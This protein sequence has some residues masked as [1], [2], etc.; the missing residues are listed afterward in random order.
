M[1][2]LLDRNNDG[3]LDYGE[4][5]RGFFGEMNETRKHYV[6]KAF[7][8]IDKNNNG[9]GDSDSL[10]KFFCPSKHPSVI[11]GKLKNSEA[12]YIKII[13]IIYVFNSTCLRK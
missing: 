10:Y 7:S 12:S 8:R 2:E 1:W 5:V 4:F 3:V 11:N 9:I 13:S 6:R